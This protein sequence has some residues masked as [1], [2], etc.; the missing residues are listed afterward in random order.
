M[1]SSKRVQISS[2]E[3]SILLAISAVQRN[4]FKSVRAAAKAYNVSQSTLSRRIR[5]SAS[6]EEF[7]PQNLK[8]SKHEE[9]VLIQQIL[10]LDS[11]G[12]APT[13]ALVRAMAGSICQARGGAEPGKNWTYNFIKRTP[14]IEVRMG[15]TYECQRLQCEDPVIISEWFKLVRNVIN[16]YGILPEDTYNFDESGFQMG[17]TSCTKVVTSSQR[18]GKPKQIKPTNTEWVTLVQAGC[19]DGSTTPPFLIMKGKILGHSWFT[20][21]LPPTWTFTTSEN[22]WTTDKIGLQWLQFFHKQTAAKT[23]GSKR[24]L[25]LDNHGSHTTPEFIQF[26]EDNG[27]VLLWMPPHS[28][29]ILQPLDV[30]CCSPLKKAHSQ[31]IEHLIRNHIFHVTKETFLSTFK[32]AWFQTFTR[33]NILGGFRGAGLHPLDPDTV[34]SQLEAIQSPQQ[35]LP[36]S[37]QEWQGATPSNAR[38][39]DKQSTLIKRRMERKSISPT[40]L[41]SAVQQL[42]KGAQIMAASAA[43]LQAQLDSHIEVSKA[44]NARKKRTKKGIHAEEPMSISQGQAV[45]A[46]GL[47]ESVE[48]GEGSSIPRQPRQTARCSRC[49]QEGHDKRRCPLASIDTTL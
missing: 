36:S 41:Y 21:Q 47:I 44:Q 43:L 45:I 15:R 1:A 39:V 25:I 26:A 14:A 32:E 2:N 16:K 30:G 19:A 34:L 27:I 13:L 7:T 11:Q 35:H 42:A 37:S 31:Q 20:L 8:L 23:I 10:N 28:S 18:Q 6:R 22:G 9:D 17:S 29:H 3:G 49:R 24:L 40:P 5:G 46:L 12:L 33:S 4:Q 48:E 38:E